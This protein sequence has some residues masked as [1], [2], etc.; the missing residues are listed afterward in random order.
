MMPD[1][2]Q[3]STGII[4]S[5]GSSSTLYNSPDKKLNAPTGL[6][7]NKAGQIWIGTAFDGLFELKR[8]K[9]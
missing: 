7:I 4:Y 5:D 3:L 6:A 9:Q 1:A 8:A 2:R